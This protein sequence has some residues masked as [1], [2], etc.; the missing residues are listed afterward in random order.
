MAIDDFSLLD[1]SRAQLARNLASFGLDGEVLEGDAFELLRD[2]VLAD[3]SIGVFYYDGPHTFDA[4]LDALALVAPY[5]A[6]AAIVI[7]D[8]TDRVE[9]ARA[10]RAYVRR[11]TRATLVLELGGDGNPSGP[12]GEGIQ[13]VAWRAALQRGVAHA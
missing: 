12:W 6:P 1:C 3:R 9:V 7:I 5:L 8:D 2:G 10:V 13:V 4:Q 11:E